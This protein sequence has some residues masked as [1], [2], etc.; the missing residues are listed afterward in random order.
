[1][2]QFS[3]VEMTPPTLL[4][5]PNFSDGR[6]MHVITAIGRALAQEGRASSSQVAGDPTEAWC[7]GGV[8]LLDMHHDR[9]H[10]RSVFTVAGRPI[11]LA[12]AVLAGAAVAVERI[13]VMARRSDERG[14]T[15]E[16]PYVGA[17]D[18]AP[19]VYL[20][21]AARGAACAE[22]LVVADRIG[23]ELHVPVFLYGELTSADGGSERTRAE[24][25]RGGP[26]GLAGRMSA[27]LRPDFG[28]CRLHP[29][30]GATLVGSRE[31]LVA[32]NLQLAPPATVADARAIAALIREGGS[33]GLPS[34]RAIGVSV[35]GGVAQVSMN[36]ERPL[37]VPMAVAIEAVSRHAPVSSAELV[38]LAPRAALEGLPHHV[39]LHGFDPARHVIE[40]A[41]GF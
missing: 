2:A 6:D 38:G 40:N 14:Q 7:E 10:H 25:R 34:V 23:G 31:P 30:A 15:G 8:R 41:L 19:V 36:I 39:P 27:G 37:E 29:T 16:H 3:L 9:D 12:D 4:A 18:V 13:N 22:A 21:A 11:E 24:L 32:F 33:E 5:V 26:S 1:V 20:D 35:S 28:P 17:L